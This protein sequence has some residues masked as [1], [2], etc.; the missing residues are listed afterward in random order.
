MLLLVSETVTSGIITQI[1]QLAMLLIANSMVA[2]G[3]DLLHCCHR[4]GIALK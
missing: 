2:D 3:G 4:M 1:A